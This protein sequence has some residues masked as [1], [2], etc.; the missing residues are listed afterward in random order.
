MGSYLSQTSF[1]TRH[2]PCGTDPEGGI[3][4]DSDKAEP[5]LKAF[6]WQHLFSWDPWLLL[7][8]VHD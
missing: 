5:Q 2:M 7:A 6:E 3:L 4:W 8:E 1:Y